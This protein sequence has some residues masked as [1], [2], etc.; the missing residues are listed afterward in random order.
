MLKAVKELLVKSVSSGSLEEF[1]P[2]CKRTVEN[3]G[4]RYT[5]EEISVDEY[6]KRAVEEFN[7]M[8]EKYGNGPV[9]KT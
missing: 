8:V 7:K 4:R 9:K 3:N 1:L 6:H 2:S 5:V